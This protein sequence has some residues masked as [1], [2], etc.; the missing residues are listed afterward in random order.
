MG[1]L[2]GIAYKT[3]KYGPMLTIPSAM[4]SIET[5]LADDYRG[6]PGK[7]QLTVMSNEAFLAA[8]DELKASLPWT[9]RRANLLITGIGLENSSGQFLR[10]GDLVLE[11]TGETEPCSRMDDQHQGL[12]EA[13]QPSWRGGVTCRV[14][15]SGAISVG[16]EV[17]LTKVI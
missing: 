1:Q 4:V 16:D 11:I 10:I 3:E 12:R 2:A 13:L 15:R 6:I 5:G 7:R 14:I 8:C 17:L 9:I